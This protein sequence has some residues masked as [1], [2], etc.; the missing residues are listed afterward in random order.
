MADFGVTETL[1]AISAATAA[2]GTGVSVAGQMQAGAA[3]KAAADYNAQ[4]DR[5]KAQA[6]LNA[7]QA[8]AL[9]VQQQTRKKMGEAAAAFAAGGV[10]ITGTPL[11]VLNDQAVQGELTRQ[12]T[13]YKGQVAA[14]ALDQQAGADTYAGNVAAAAGDV[15][16]G[17]TL[18]TGTSQIFGP[19]GSGNALITDLT[20]P[21]TSAGKSPAS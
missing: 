3:Q 14:D 1:L 2:V 5:I 7:A 18:L 9:Q 4:V 17:S 8:D 12:L 6:Q 13:L 21:S 10:D 16:A 19:S 11:M 15:K 20:K